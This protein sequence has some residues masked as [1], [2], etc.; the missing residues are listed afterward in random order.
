MFDV[1]RK[2]EGGPKRAFFYVRAISLLLLTVSMIMMMA[3]VK[4]SAT[5]V[6]NWT[7]P[8]TNMD[9]SQLTDLQGYKVYYGSGSPCNFTNTINI[10]NVTPPS[11]TLSL[12]NGTYCVAVTAYD[13][14][15]YESDYSNTVYKTEGTSDITAPT[16]TAFTI[17]GTSVSLTVPVTTFTATDNVLV[18]GYMVNESSTKPLATASGWSASAPASYTCTTAGSKTLYAW[19]KDAAGNVSASL[20]ASVTI[21]LADTTAPT[22]NTFTVPATATSLTVAVSSL[23]AT[24]DVLVTGY[25][26]NESSTKPLATASGWSAS[27]PASYTCNTAGSKTLYAWAKD[28]A[29]NVSASRSASVTITLT[30][31]T[32]P[33][34]NTFTVPATATS[35]TVA[36]SSLTATD[37]VLVTGYMVNESSTKPLATASGWSAS[38][39]ASYTCTTAGSK[40][41]YA[42]AKDAAGNVSA[43]R[44]ASVTIGAGSTTTIYMNPTEDTF[45]NLDTTNNSGSQ[46][47]NTYT[48]PDDMD[49]NA[50]LMKFDLSGIPAGAV[51]QSA[52]LNLYLLDTDTNSSY[53]TYNISLNR[54]V[55]HNPDLSKA[56]GFTYDGIN[57]WTT[58]TNCYNNVPLGQ[59][60][61]SAAYD[62]EATDK[63]L[64]FKGW[65]ATQL[66]D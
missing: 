61:I 66:I 32:A 43:S 8:T 20:S 37:N 28:A 17:P 36:V 9:G 25:M 65:N 60:D 21:T 51:I 19:A 63:S 54:I 52:T 47:L 50:I 35:L 38:A 39:P 46:I 49:A 26:V 3:V 62:I 59:A 2:K 22:V 7:A 57:S 4:A 33:T 40:T 1:M 30:D 48:W 27:A 55:N 34:V 31:T 41:L 18:T 29:G 10:G 13:A 15:G 14:A 24:D 5:I 53:P 42:W 11:Y 23:T 56:T 12:P 44:S 16:V 58:N 6:L 64:G 45:I